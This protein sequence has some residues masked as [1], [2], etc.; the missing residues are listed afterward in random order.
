M[1]NNL[2][3]CSAFAT[4][5]QC[6]CNRNAVHLKSK[7]SAFEAEMQCISVANAVHFN[8]W[9]VRLLFLMLFGVIS[10]FTT[11]QEFTRVNWDELAPSH[12]LP[13]ITEEFPLTD[14]FRSYNYRVSLEFPEFE[15]ANKAEAIELSKLTETLPA[16]PHLDKQITVSA[17][18][19]FLTVRFIPVVFRNGQFCKIQSYKLSVIP[20]PIVT[21][22]T[23]ERS[24]SFA[25]NS[26]LSTG[27]FVKISIPEDGVYTITYSELRQM[28]FPDPSKIKLLGY[29]G[30]LLSLKFDE[31]PADDLPELPLYHINNSILFFGKGVTS[32][33]VNSRQTGFIREQ[34]F[35][36]NNACY[37][38]TDSGNTP[39]EF[40][41]EASLPASNHT[42]EV[43]NDY[44]LHEKDSWS[45]AATGRELY[46]DYDY[47]TG[48]SRRYTFKLPGITAGNAYVTAEFAAR[49][50]GQSTT[51]NISVDGNQLGQNEIPEVPSANSYYTKAT[52]AVIDALWGG[53]KKE[54]VQFTITHVRPSGVSG[55]LN[56]L[57][58]NYQRRL[59]LNS[60]FLNFR[61]LASV[62]KET[63]FVITGANEATVVW[64]VTSASQYKQITGTLTGDTY[65]FTIPAGPLREFVA[66]NT[67]SSFNN[68]SVT[69]TIPNQNL[70]AM[71]QVDMVILVPDKK[72][73][74]TQAERLAQA[75]REKDALSVAIITAPQV[76]NEFSSGTPDATAYRRLMKMLYDRSTSEADRPKYLLLFGDCSYDNRM[77]SPTWKN[78]SPDDFLLC[79]QSENSLNEINSY[80][81]DDYFGF[82]DD[83]EG[84][85]LSTAKLDI[86]IGRF[87]VRT[88]S[89]AKA[90]VDKT[91]AYMEN[92]EAGPWKHTICYAADDGDN[93]LHIT[94]AEILA[95]YTEQHQPSFLIKR[96]YEDAFKREATATGYSYPNAT[97]QLLRQFEQG[98]FMVNYTGHGSTSAWTAENLLTIE[99]I[100]NL[101]SPRLPLWV[102]ATCDFTRFDDINTSAGELA[103]LNPKGGAIALLTTTRV[104]Y[105][106]QNSTLNQAF[107][108]HIFD[109]PNG[110]RLRLGDIMRL[111]KC[112]ISLANDRN[113]LNFSL[114]G[115]PALTLAYPDYHVEVEEFNG[116]N[117]SE[118][119]TIK[120]G[121]RVTVKGRI[122]DADGNTA[123]DFTGTLH[124]SVFDSKEE[125]TT[126][127]NTGEGAYTYVERNKVLFSGSYPVEQGQFEFTFPVPMDINYS[128]EQGMLNL[129]AIDTNRREA[130]GYFDSFLVGGTDGGAPDDKEG[131]KMMLYL[132]TPDFPW[133]GKT[134]E[135]PLFVAQLEDANGINTVGNGIGHDL[136]LIINGQ[137]GLTYALNDYFTP[138]PGDFTRGTVR[139]SIPGL[140]EGN[141]TLQFRA[142][143]LMNNSSTSTL[144][145]EV[146][147]GLRPGLFSIETTHSPARDNTTFILSHNRPGSTL[148]VTITVYDFSGRPL[149]IHTERG[150]S[151]DNYYYVD[152]DL[153]SNGGQRLAPGVYI[154]SGSI[155][156]GDSKES[157]KSQKIV[158][159]AQ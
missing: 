45:W 69:G 15:P 33:K 10:L 2:P 107:I 31:H 25:E 100:N 48:N 154:Y 39:L 118:Y 105:A 121:G 88:E 26:V 9:L 129:Y 139:F 12:T 23:R 78:H 41:T 159:L 17:H 27:K 131:P 113:K 16:T 142:W 103:F 1:A 156:S 83:N 134:N 57:A 46:E 84:A 3:E 141:H 19:G 71:P 132:N 111:A 119:T 34:N 104:V 115:D 85:D 51:F 38:L 73:L 37:F 50:L 40:P 14:D 53:E 56:Y 136:T 76:Y 149:W 63:T 128:N 158:I 95:K 4:E 65:T 117:T 22:I 157:T 108:K 130:G 55:R 11:A 32:W 138:A 64:D 13:V 147:K 59:S 133:G 125:V 7:C 77:I 30:H 47:I 74:I 75:H 135:T 148:D 155:T 18:Q 68:V 72:G 106:S 123:N 89:E 99:H 126:L 92:K 124:P 66:V 152:W 127:N 5:M 20:E 151:A 120:A 94:Q 62:E 82:L 60:S 153:C 70:H 96:V 90:T 8:R 42:I 150:M 114:I 79:Y 61:S 49:S 112:D 24:L 145:F 91:I 35:Y 144:D 97:Q 137:A 29:G 36:A 86:G 81:T 116:S 21:R 28:G 146:V 98:I 58:V 67:A 6:I 54:D 93:N 101:T 110:K 109:K 80:I 52:S 143:D 44:I 87:P 43:F 102:T 122:L 140:P